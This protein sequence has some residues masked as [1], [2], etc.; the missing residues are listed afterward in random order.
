VRHS[1]AGTVKRG[2]LVLAEPA[3][4]R[5]TLAKHEGRMVTVTLGPVRRGRSISQN[6]YLW[7]VVYK[8]IAEWC[9]HTEAEIHRA[10]KL[11]FLKPPPPLVLP[12]GEE[13]AQEATT[14]TLSIEE[15]SDFVSKVVA[16]AAN[17]GVYVPA[18]NEVEV[19]L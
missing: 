19:A 6:N 15:F 14:T 4:W 10:M 2:Q 9:G 7:G 1:F 16:W 5:G 8:S 18:P 12:T 11:Q 13:L 17:C 3:R